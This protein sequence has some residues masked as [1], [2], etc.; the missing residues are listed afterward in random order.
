M[1]CGL[2]GEKLKHSYSPEIHQQ[3]GDY[4]YTLFERT[5]DS[6][7]DFFKS[8]KFTGLNVTIPYK[9]T[10]ISYCNQIS[11]CARQL[12][13]VNTIIRK[14]D[15]T[16]IG[17]NT[18]YFG[19]LYMVRRSG[20]DVAQKKVLVLG[21]GGA[22]VTV[23]AVL[24]ELGAKPIVI[25]RTGKNN[26]ENLHNHK[27]ATVIVNTTPV[28]MYPNTGVSPIN[29]DVFPNLEGVLDLIY[30]P[31]RTQLLLDAQARNIKTE[32][33]LSMLVSQAWESAQWFTGKTCPDV[34]IT[35]ILNQ[36]QRKMKN[37]VLIGMPGSG[38][39][40]IGKIIA[41]KYN[42]VFVD[43]DEEIVK[44]A[45][46]P[47]PEIFAKYGESYFR[48]LE[49]NVLSQLGKE[50]G[51]IIA[52]GGGCITRAENYPLLHQ[53]STILWLQR[54]ISLLPTDGRPLSQSNNLHNMYKVR[55]PLY[56]SFADIV[57]DNSESIEKTLTTLLEFED[58]L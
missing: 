50:S 27:D 36:L 32:N 21:S 49:T 53:N 34:L 42:K 35:H 6:L 39:T 25:S 48:E 55:E 20:I 5:P 52:T 24:Q 1:I 56:K 51:L 23:V 22:S 26:Y 38:K 57:I 19:F 8:T 31:C 58:L 46:M 54:D 45:G 14:P 37:I 40:T 12:G 7:D 10:V 33:G 44:Q 18:D 41:E 30:N 4:T 2:L 16:L 29:L 3:L 47:I 43:S 13:A 15:N 11:D 17:H 9:K 28:G